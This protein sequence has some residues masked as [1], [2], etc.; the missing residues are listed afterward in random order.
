MHNHVIQNF[1]VK[2]R[3]VTA[4]ELKFNGLYYYVNTQ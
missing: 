3:I 1:E 4:N 2:F